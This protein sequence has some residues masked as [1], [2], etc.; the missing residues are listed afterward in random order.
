MCAKTKPA[1][2]L[3]I[4]DDENDFLLIQLALRKAA[5]TAKLF[6]VPDAGEAMAYLQGRAP[7]EDRVLNPAPTLI[8]TDLRLPGMSG[9]ELID[10][11]RQRPEY[12]ATPIV[13][14]SGLLDPGLGSQLPGTHLC[15]GKTTDFDSYAQLLCTLLAPEAAA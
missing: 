5:F 15:A 6:R 2:V 9:F 12:A 14:F 10:W 8:C 3:L 1:I 13:V 11:V 7:F 4:E